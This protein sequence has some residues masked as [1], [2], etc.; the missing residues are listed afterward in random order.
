M[1]TYYNVWVHIEE[2]SGEE[3]EEE[4]NDMDEKFMPIKIGIAKSEE[5]I[6]LVYGRIENA[7]FDHFFGGTNA[8]FLWKDKSGRGETGMV[9]LQSLVGWVDE[10]VTSYDGEQLDEWA[11]CAEIGDTWENSTDSYTRIS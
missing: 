4:Y 11:Q 2:V 7:Q 3:G 9:T 10:D 5:E 1:K 6:N 8:Q